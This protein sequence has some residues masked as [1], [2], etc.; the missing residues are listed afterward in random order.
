MFLGLFTKLTIPP[1]SLGTLCHLVQLSTSWRRKVLFTPQRKA[2]RDLFFTLGFWS[3]Q[4]LR[5]FPPLPAN[6]LRLNKCSSYRL[7]SLHSLRTG[8]WG[9]R[10]HRYCVS[11]WFWSLIFL[12]SVFFF[13]SAWY[14]GTQSEVC[15]DP[16]FSLWFQPTYYP[17]AKDVSSERVLRLEKCGK[18]RWT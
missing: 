18:S 9:T 17:P 13:N 10:V 16:S 5:G 1:V 14:F 8:V 7:A 12:F 6:P 2:T 11:F 15:S 3:F 4:G